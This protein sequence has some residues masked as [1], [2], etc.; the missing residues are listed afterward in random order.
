[1]QLDERLDALSRQCERLQQDHHELLQDQVLS[2]STLAWLG[3]PFVIG[4]MLVLGGMVWSSAAVLGWPVA[5]LGLAGWAI[6]VIAKVA[7]ERSAAQELEQCEKQLELLQS[8]T[9]QAKQEQTQ[10]DEQLPR[11]AGSLDGRLASAD[12]DLARFEELLPL[13]ANLQA[14]RQRVQSLQRRVDQLDAAVKESRARWRSALRHCHLPEN[15]S[16]QAVRQLAQGNERTRQFQ[17]HLQR[18]RDELAAREQELTALT[19]RV[20]EMMEQVK[21]TSVSDDPQDQLQRLTSA[22]AQQQQLA[23]RRQGLSQEDR[24]IQRQGR[25]LV[26]ELRRARAQCRATVAEAGAADEKELRHMSARVEQRQAMEQECE[27]VSGQFLRALGSRCDRESVERELVDHAQT[28]LEQ[29]RHMLAQRLSETRAQLAAIHQQRGAVAQESKTLIADRQLADVKLELGCVEQ[30][31]AE[32]VHRW[33]VLAVSAQVLETV[34]QIYETHRQPQTLK[35]ASRYFEAL[36][37]GQYVRIW[38]PLTDMALRVDTVAGDALPLDVLSCGTREAVFL[39]LR[40]ALVVDFSRRGVVLPLVLDDVLVNFDS[41]RAKAAADVLCRFADSGHQVLMF[42]CHEHIVQLFEAA[43]VEIRYLSEYAPATRHVV[44]APAEPVPAEVLVI[45]PPEVEVAEE[46]YELEEAEIVDDEEDYDEIEYE[47]EDEEEV[48]E[49]ET[50]DYLL[51]VFEEA[52]VEE[53]E[54]DDL[55][56]DEDYEEEDEVDEEEEY[57]ED[58]EEDGRRGRGRRRRRGARRG[59]PMRRRRARGAVPRGRRA[60]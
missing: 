27:E 8:Q 53:A 23:A 57:D 1:M 3:V 15:L 35:D 36:T 51:D 22:L 48:L 24:Q 12:K 19:L 28:E 32:A 44:I 16:P 17:R 52:E 39:S 47:L 56:D 55:D 37:E 58:E 6:A 54:V 14:T 21:L 20:E 40:L 42:T 30:Q 43:H 9:K 29:R 50:P 33:R 41:R 2:L 10:L 45:E 38:T 60:R 18:R 26:K 49:P 7:L 11:S 25:K 4:V 46:E 5:T 59:R 34:R 31:L 13:E